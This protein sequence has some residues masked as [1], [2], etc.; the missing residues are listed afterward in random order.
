MSGDREFRGR[1]DPL[2]G[3]PPEVVDRARG[4]RLLLLDVDGVLTDGGLR[5]TDTGGEAKTFHVHD[6]H[7][8]KMLQAG[9]IPVGI[10]TSR[11][12]AVVARR[13][14]EL[15]IAHVRQGCGDKREAFAALLEQL[16]I[17]AGAVAYVG[18]DVIDL[19]VMTRVG[20]AVAVA[21]AHPEV[22]ARAHWVTAS[23]GGR[24]AV[25]E[26]CDLLLAAAERYD[27]AL[28]LYL[29]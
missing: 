3:V 10:V 9:G 7:G 5:Y 26:T 25:R 19:P 29:G 24:G 12:S 23:A 27:A 13:A 8:V 14:T 18:D 1:H 15:G 11:E 22:R 16:R 21:N 6:G 4:V 20:L 17:E 28:A 2:D